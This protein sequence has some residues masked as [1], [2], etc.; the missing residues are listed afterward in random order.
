M[1]QRVR[2]LFLHN[3]K[4]DW[5]VVAL[6]IV[7]NL[8]VAINAVWHHPKIGYDA[9]DNITY[10]QVLPHR[11]P[12]PTDTGEF[13][14]PPLPFLLPAL[15]D[16]LCTAINPGELLP[17]GD[18]SI[19]WSCRTYDGKFA[20]ALNL[21]LSIGTT[22]LLLAIARQLRPDD[23]PFRLSILI[24]LANLT[25]YYK[26]FAQVRGE[27]YVVFFTVLSI[28]LIMQLVK[29]DSFSWKSVSMTGLSLGGLIL[30]RQWGFF[31]YPAIGLFLVMIF[32]R[33]HQKGRLLARH[34]IVS[35]SISLLVGGF[36]YFHLYRD[37]GSFSA[38]NIDKP[39]YPSLQQAYSLLRKTHLGNLELFR[40]PVR[41]AFAGAILPILYSETWGD[42]WGY[43]TF[44]KPNS[45]FGVNGYT[46]S[47]TFAAYL[48][49]VNLLSVPATLLLVAG[50]VFSVAQVLRSPGL[51][52]PEREYML[53]ICLV[54]LMMLLGFSWFIYS[55]VLASTKVLK[56]TYM[57]QGLVVLLIPAAAALE[58]I[59]ARSSKAYLVIIAILV[60]AFIHNVPAMITHYSVFA[61]L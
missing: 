40:Q 20:Q 56:A 7:I 17:F 48:G 3:G 59:R 19:S 4:P 58:T 33:D 10:I 2:E 51:T 6:F 25:V 54:M 60:I 36:F 1:F 12:E 21:L 16:T 42:Y 5:L 32:L 13:F 61:F 57:L 26:T 49:R 55:Y 43:F 38:F 37:Y 47:D 15:Y 14:S 52:G 8:L 9:V 23:R 44:I 27:P 30:S 41:P 46:N 11:M 50:L 35:G 53:L 18:F 22:I 29:S 45:S 39:N 24:L 28:I 34:L 31:I